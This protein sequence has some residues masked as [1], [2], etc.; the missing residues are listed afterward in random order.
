MRTS[1]GFLFFFFLQDYIQTGISL[2]ACLMPPA[3]QEAE[4]VESTMLLHT[5]PSL[6]FLK[7]FLLCNIFLISKLLF[8]IG[9]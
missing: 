5:T 7:Y 3:S 4:S 9:V 1:S 6:S 2:M 8:Y